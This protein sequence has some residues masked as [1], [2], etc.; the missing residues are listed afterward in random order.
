MKTRVIKQ[1]L[2][3][4]GAVMLASCEEPAPIHYPSGELT[5]REGLDNIFGR[6][7]SDFSADAEVDILLTAGSETVTTNF[8]YQFSRPVEQQ[9]S[10]TLQV[11]TRVDDSSVELLPA[12]NYVFPDGLTL[13][14]DKGKHSSPSMRL[15]LK[16]EGLAAGAYRLSFSADDGSTLTYNLTVRAKDINVMPPLTTE[17]NMVFY[18]NTSDYQPLLADIWAIREFDISSNETGY[19]T[20]GSIV[21][22]RKASVGYNSMTENVDFIIDFDLAHCLDDVNKYIRPLQDKGRKVCICIEGNGTGY[23]FCN[24]TDSQISDLVF[25]IK[26]ALDYYGLD[27]VHLF[28]RESGYGKAGAPSVNSTSYAKFIKALREGLGTDKLITL[29]D[30][31]EPTENFWNTRSTGGISVGDYIDY[32][33]SGYMSEKE[34]LQILDVYHCIPSPADAKK[35][36]M[37][38]PIT[39]HE[40]RKPIAGLDV[41]RFGCIALP[42]YPYNSRDYIDQSVLNMTAWSSWNPN[43]I[44]VVADL[45]PN[46]QGLY[47]GLSGGTIYSLLTYT[48]PRYASFDYIITPE[49]DPRVNTL[50]YNWFAKD[51]Y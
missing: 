48:T 49:I 31:E 21:N 24:L 8:H 20:V 42:N 37:I 22:L 10:M 2:A 16:A 46:T 12:A 30:Y 3:V 18:V 23:G 43:K 44:L 6:L 11:A 9:V 13:S 40:E 15:I 19:F 5:S 25:K 38:Y 1:I 50:F 34:Q 35:K 28:D 51:W 47:E 4:I 27:G 7:R 45:R 36:G 17:F 39:T 26:T 33:W 29:A 14:V 32:A 41:S